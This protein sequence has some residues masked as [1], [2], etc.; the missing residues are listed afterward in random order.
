MTTFN[1]CADCPLEDPSVEDCIMRFKSGEVGCNNS[2][3]I[4]INVLAR[5]EAL[6]NK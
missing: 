4:L 1:K 2:D 5:L 6:E 3:N